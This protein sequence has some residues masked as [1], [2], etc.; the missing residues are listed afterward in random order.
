MS[1]VTKIGCTT[2]SSPKY[3]AMAWNTNVPP[4]KRRPTSQSGWRTR[5]RAPRQPFWSSGRDTEA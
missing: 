5:A 1:S 2:A 4:M 3:K